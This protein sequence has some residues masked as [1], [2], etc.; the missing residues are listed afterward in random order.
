MTE[1]KRKHDAVLHDVC[2]SNFSPFRFFNGNAQSHFYIVYRYF[3]FV[4][5]LFWQKNSLFSRLDKF[6]RPNKVF[7]AKIRILL[8][9][10]AL[11]ISDCKFFTNK[12]VNPQ[13][14]NSAP[15]KRLHF[16]SVARG[17]AA[18]TQYKHTK[19]TRYRNILCSWVRR[20]YSCVFS[21]F[22]IEKLIVF[23]L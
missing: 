23:V 16:P 18:K 1:A 5:I 2:F 12:I 8:L 9:I 3:T 17:G 22:S 20:R 4:N 13:T 7:K 11:L 19:S 14:K 10:I 15:S 21:L 6:L